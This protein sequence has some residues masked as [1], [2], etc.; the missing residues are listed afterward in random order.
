MRAAV[1]KGLDQGLVIEQRPDPLPEAG[2]LLIRVARAGICGSEIHATSDPA[3]PVGGDS[4]LG[5][6]IC[7]EVIAFGAGVE[8]FRLGD[9]IVP[10]PHVGC[11]RCGACLAGKPHLCP[12]A[13]L[14]IVSGYCEYTRVGQNECIR[15]PAEV[16]DEEAALIEPLAVGLQGVRKV[17]LVVG[18]RVLVTGAGP[19]GLA[20]AFWARRL[21]AG[22]VAV[23]ASSAR[24]RAFAL[25][26]GATHFIAQREVADATQ[27]VR[28]ALG[29]AP[30]VVIEAVGLPGAIADAIAHVEPAGTVV[31]LGLCWST[32][33]F[34]P[35]VALMKEVRLQFS[36]CYARADFE[37]CATVMADGDHRPRAMITS[38]VDLDALPA[39]FE[40]LR[41]PSADCKVMVAPWGM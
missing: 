16:S 25:G 14:G 28:D 18:D 36:L 40:S 15:V 20:A 24:R 26:L 7:G 9:R 34:S 23:M 37:Y 6:E 22:R 10:M 21:G 1:F 30:D 33:H 35:A 29:G 27:A 3:R 38:T 32:D 31:S 19:I 5:H 2:E 13:R 39:K 11:G 17:G 12:E 8:R 41:G 4:I